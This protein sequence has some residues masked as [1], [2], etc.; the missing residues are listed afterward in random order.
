M[1]KV[2]RVGGASIFTPHTTHSINAN[3]H[4]HNKHKN[5]TW[6][7]WEYEVPQA[8][9]EG[10]KVLEVAVK[11]TD[12]SYNVQPERIEPYWNLV[13]SVCWCGLLLGSNGCW[14]VLEFGRARTYARTH[15]KRN[16]ARRAG[17]LLAPQD[18]RAAGG[19]GGG[20]GG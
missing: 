18:D 16:A 20:C 8:K 17:Q 14:T 4:T 5:R 10:K 2:G 11:A 7:L 12:T 9:L 6:S 1:C 15:T 19:R 3:A 13:R